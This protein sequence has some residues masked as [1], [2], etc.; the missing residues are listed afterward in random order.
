[1]S[2]EEY[3]KHRATG[4]CFRCGLKFGPTH[5]CPPK[6]LQVLVREGEEDSEHD[7]LFANDLNLEEAEFGE[8]KTSPEFQ[9]SELASF[10]FDSP[11]TMKLF[12]HVGETCFLLMIDSGASHC[13]VSEKVA[14]KLNWDVEPTARFSVLLGDGSRVHASG[15]CK[16]IPLL[17]EAAGALFYF[18]LCFSTEQCRYDFG[19]FL[20]GH[21]GRCEGKLGYFT[22]EFFVSGR[23]ICLRGD[24]TLLIRRCSSRAKHRLDKEDQGYL[25]CSL[26]NDAL[27][28]S[29]RVSEALSTAAREELIVVRFSVGQ[30][31]IRHPTSSSGA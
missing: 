13:F 7:G 14:Q 10:G 16:N 4:T 12:G 22:M 29:Y 21:F 24:P 18:L 28:D 31:P 23:H 30:H 6:T 3:L 1:M 26:N 9:L 8:P 27:E 19:S 20:V 25:L 11:Q 2:Q 17:L 5:R 15:I